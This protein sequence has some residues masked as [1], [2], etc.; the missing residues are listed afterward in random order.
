M[1]F[2]NVS[3]L[4]I[5]KS[6]MPRQQLER[7]RKCLCQIF[8]RINVGGSIMEQLH[9]ELCNTMKRSTDVLLQTF[10]MV[11]CRLRKKRTKS[12]RICLIPSSRRLRIVRNTLKKCSH[13]VGTRRQRRAQRMKQW[14]GQESF[15]KSKNSK[16]GQSKSETI[17]RLR[18]E[19]QSHPYRLSFSFNFND[20][21][22]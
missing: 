12:W 19:R 16:I 10:Y 13:V 1:T 17:N 21:E 3:S 11:T 14:R 20:D 18:T 15:R 22:F 6:Q 8:I 5:K 2:K 7:R 9:S 4:K